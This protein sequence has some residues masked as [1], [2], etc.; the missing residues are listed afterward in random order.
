MKRILLASIMLAAAACGGKSYD[1]GTV[2]TTQARASIDQIGAVSASMSS[3][4]G[5]EAAGAVQ[6]MTAA[7]QGIVTPAAQ[8]RVQGLIPDFSNK[9]GGVLSALGG[10][11]ECS[12]TA[13]TFTNYGDD[14]AGW[15]INGT[16]NNSGGTYTFDLTYDISSFGST[17][18]WT[19]DGSL[20]VTDTSIDGEINSSGK[21]TFEGGGGA[22]S[23]TINWD[24]SVDYR[25]V[26]L[27]PSG[28]PTGGSVYATTS[29]EVS[30][31]QGSG[32]YAVEGTAT[33]GPGCAQ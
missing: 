23:A 1:P 28:C 30:S 27:D 16:I 31:S 17:L 18:K 11:A 19:I 29:Y 13:C 25:D 21:S 12:A 7:S 24:V 8:G 14:A 22:G 20:T 32:S 6:A 4:N 15:L 33:F 2:N 10:T 5:A 3:M 26:V 9:D